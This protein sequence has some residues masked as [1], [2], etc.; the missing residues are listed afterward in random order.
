MEQSSQFIVKINKW[1][2]FTSGM[3]AALAHKC[4]QRFALD[5]RLVHQQ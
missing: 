5:F 2:I 4:L 1:A 3:R